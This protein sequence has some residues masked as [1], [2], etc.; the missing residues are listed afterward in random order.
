M[1]QQ[2]SLDGTYEK[3]KAK[4]VK[5]IDKKITRALVSTLIDSVAI[6][7]TPVIIDDEIDDVHDEYAKDVIGTIGLILFA[8]ELDRGIKDFNM[9]K[10]LLEKKKKVLSIK[11][12]YEW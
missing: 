7:A 6:I 8:Y 9:L 1:N 3:S 2:D 12:N 5:I 10:F 11:R 4:L